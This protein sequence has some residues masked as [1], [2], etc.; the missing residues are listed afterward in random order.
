LETTFSG[1]PGP[2]LAQ[3][4]QQQEATANS[5][6][7]AKRLGTAFGHFTKSWQT[8]PPDTNIQAPTN[9][10]NFAKLQFTPSFVSKARD[11]LE[12]SL[13]DRKLEKTCRRTGEH[14]EKPAPENTKERKIRRS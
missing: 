9:R 7:K 6:Q 8:N 14:Q 1:D 11:F 5:T 4:G 13:L 3:T 2:G 10:G 12:I